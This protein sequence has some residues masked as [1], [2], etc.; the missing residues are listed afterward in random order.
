MNLLS[1]KIENIRKK[2]RFEYFDEVFG[3]SRWEDNRFYITKFLWI[4]LSKNRFNISSIQKWK[5]KKKNKTKKKKNK[6]KK[7]INV[8]NW[9]YYI[10]KFL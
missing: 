8:C 5:K 6:K 1:S 9:K 2:N 4:N 7:C 3:V 10:T